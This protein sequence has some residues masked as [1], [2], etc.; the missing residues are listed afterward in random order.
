M[1]STSLRLSLATA[2]TRRLV[3]GNTAPRQKVDERMEMWKI[4]KSP[5]PKKPGVHAGLE[6]QK[7]FLRKFIVYQ[8]VLLWFH[9]L[10]Q[11]G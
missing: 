1:S 2:D 3:I 7:N 6:M 4:L 9:R 10:Q 11:S 8:E 5:R